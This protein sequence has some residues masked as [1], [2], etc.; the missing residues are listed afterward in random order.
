MAL[1]K[2]KTR[3][4]KEKINP[5]L[6]L[7]N[8][9]EKVK[10]RVRKN[11]AKKIT[12]LLMLSGGARSTIENKETQRIIERISVGRKFFLLLIFSLRALFLDILNFSPIEC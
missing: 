9:T 8:M 6:V 5:R 12:T 11:T 3:A 7:F 2:K 1:S 4:R 10:R